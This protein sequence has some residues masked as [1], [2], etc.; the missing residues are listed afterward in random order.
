M[1]ALEQLLAVALDRDLHT[2]TIPPKR[3]K[4]QWT[5]TTAKEQKMTNQIV[6]LYYDQSLCV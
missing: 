6:A 3:P 4:Q 1:Q 5:E 2:I